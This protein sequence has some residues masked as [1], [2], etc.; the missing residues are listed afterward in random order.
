MINKIYSN[1]QTFKALNL[2]DGLNILVTHKSPTSDDKNTRNGSGKS[3]LIE[4]INFIFGA[5]T[6]PKSIFKN[7]VFST[8]S[9]SIDI[10][11][12]KVKYTITR[13]IKSNKISIFNH[14]HQ[15]IL[16]F[17]SLTEANQYF[18]GLLFQIEKNEISFRSLFPYFSRS[19]NDGGFID[20]TKYNKM[21]KKID[22]Q[23][24]LT[25]LLGLDRDI[26]IEWKNLKKREKE[27][28]D[29][30][31]LL[32]N[33]PINNSMTEAEIKTALTILD[34]KVSTLSTQ[35]ENFNVLPEYKHLEKEANE[36]TISI[37]D[38]LNEV[39]MLKIQV[40]DINKSLHSADKDNIDSLEKLYSEINLILP[41]KIT[42]HFKDVQKFHESV[43]NNRNNYLMEEI[44][45][46]QENISI[47]EKEISDK[48]LR[49][50]L[51]MQTLSNK[52]ALE[53]YTKMQ[54]LY[55]SLTSERLVLKNQLETFKKID[56]SQRQINYRKEELK[57]LLASDIEK[58]NEIIKKAI[59][60]FTHASEYLYGENK[61]GQLIINTTNENGLT[62]DIQKSDRKSKGINNM[63]IFCFDMMLLE[64]S[65]FLNRPIDFLIH[66]SH[67]F[68]GVDKRQ[69]ARALEYADKI[70]EINNSQY[71]VLLNSDIYD[72]LSGDFSKA[73]L[74]VDIT[75]SSEN[76]GLFGFRF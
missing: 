64:I 8:A 18:G 22:I 73:R 47:I 43:I 23:N 41:E 51:I 19:E 58:N 4:I 2:H 14:N 24:S 38:M 36:L 10:T 56:D 74:K 27:I 11:I 6:N 13:N 42:K 70:C 34:D 7:Q 5:K 29:L 3:S 69:I 32:K 75:D 45:N 67:L 68:D 54:N 15:K 57:L 46:L 61:G 52:G 33:N 31:R 53:E 63:M 50:Q 9:F 71:F 21:Q 66:D 16:H 17:K 40:E 20:P 76:G 30:K 25:F 39:Q 26:S 35:I 44:R 28:K 55:N 59:L 1:I 60:S 49:K 37:S 62:I 12:N 72:S 48:S 65:L